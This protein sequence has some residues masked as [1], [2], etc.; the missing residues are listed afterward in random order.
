MASTNTSYGPFLL[1]NQKIDVEVLKDK[2]GTYVLGHSKSNSFYPK[3]VGRSDDDINGRL[4][5]WVGKYQEFK[6]SYHGTAKDAYYHEC[7]VYHDFKSSLDNEV[8]PAKP[9]GSSYICPVCGE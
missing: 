7:R 1:T 9:S 5:D 3:Y 2:I 6:L 8:H 4:K